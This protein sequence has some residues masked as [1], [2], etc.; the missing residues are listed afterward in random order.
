MLSDMTVSF[1]IEPRSTCKRSYQRRNCDEKK[2]SSKTK[3]FHGTDS[4]HKN[5][6]IATYFTFQSVTLHPNCDGMLR[7]RDEMFPKKCPIIVP[8][9]K[10]YAYSIGLTLFYSLNVPL[11]G[12]KV[13]HLMSLKV[14][15]YDRRRIKLNFRSAQSKNV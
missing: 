13:F 2:N 3:I 15:E 11:S 9:S 6:N 10:I 4:G 5:P 7:Q 1:H 12:I 14:Q 8:T